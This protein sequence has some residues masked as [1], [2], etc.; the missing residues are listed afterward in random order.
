MSPVLS[1]WLEVVDRAARTWC[2]A[3]AAVLLTANG[4]GLGQ[5]DW[6]QAASIAG[7]AALASI[8]TSIGTK[9][10][11]VSTNT[12]SLLLNRSRGRHHR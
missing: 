7:V 4:I 10:F 8:G 9:G 5:V 3:F 11:G 12:P 2:Q 6:R 1:Y